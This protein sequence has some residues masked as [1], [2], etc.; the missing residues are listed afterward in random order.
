MHPSSSS[1]KHGVYS[2]TCSTRPPRSSRPQA[3]RAP[4][5][6]VQN[7]EGNPDAR[8]GAV[9]PAMLQDPQVLVEAPEEN[10]NM[11]ALA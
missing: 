3:D 8:G 5:A 2:V 6:G 4:R 1:L 10:A 7:Q 11:F 9:L